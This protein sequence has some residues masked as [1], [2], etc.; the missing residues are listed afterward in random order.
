MKRYLSLLLACALL[1]SA[2]CAS[3]LS[4]TD[5]D[6][7][8]WYW[9]LTTLVDDIGTR[10]VGKGDGLQI[11][12]D[13]LREEF[14]QYGY[15]Y[16]D[17]TLQEFHAPVPE[18]NCDDTTTLIA[19]KR[20]VNPNPKIITV[21]AHYDSHQ[22]GARDNASGVATMLLMMR[23]FNDVTYDDTEIRFIA[24]SAEES[25]HQ[26]SMGYCGTLTQDEIDRSIAAFNVDIFVKD[27]WD[28]DR[29]L[30]MDTMGIRTEDGY[31]EATEEEPANNL[32]ARA[33]R[34][35]MIELDYFPEEDHEIT[36]CGPRFLGM[37]DHESFHRFGI[38]S[39]NFCFRGNTASGGKWPE[40]MHSPSDIMGDFDL[41][42]S[43]QGLEVLYTA[44]D[45]LARSHH[46]YAE[47]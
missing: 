23:L 13:Y 24:F 35:A 12:C 14:Q 32:P 27:I 43:W 31:I 3:A 19:I 47:Q 37:S 28:D 16:E 25:G 39:V 15:S 17:G 36:W 8:Y 21:C 11:A 2:A 45:G 26:G 41:D 38:E 22:P 5:E 1:C 29:V 18:W 9:E 40:Y 42:I 34:T 44:M 10:L 20:A 30:S 6:F 7:D 46:A 33:L 4:I